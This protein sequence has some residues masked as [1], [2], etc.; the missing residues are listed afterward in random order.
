MIK[1]NKKVTKMSGMTNIVFDFRYDFVY[2]RQG[3][4]V[5]NHNI[6]ISDLNQV[7]EFSD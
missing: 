5:L 3:E 2:P 1:T 7:N 6:K 4:N